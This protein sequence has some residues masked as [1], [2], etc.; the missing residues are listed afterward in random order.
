[1]ALWHD[2]ASAGLPKL[3]L[4]HGNGLNAL[5]QIGLMDAL[6]AQFDVYGVDFRGHGSTALPL[7]ATPEDPWG[8]YVDD[9]EALIERH[10]DG[11]VRYAGHSLSGVTGIRLALRR[12]DLFAHL[13]PIDPAILP[14]IKARL[15]PL[16]RKLG[17]T[18][19]VNPL[20][21]G[22]LV[23]R[24]TW[25]DRAAAVAYFTGRK[26]FATWPEA[27]VAGY[28]DGGLRAQDGGPTLTLT[29]GREWEARTFKFVPT[30][31]EHRLRDLRIPTTLIRAERGSIFPKKLRLS[32]TTDLQILP[33]T[34]F[35]H[36]ERP[37]AT[38]AIICK[39]MG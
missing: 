39:A 37:E 29:C 9:L 22:T 24:N 3:L 14:S 31:I 28:I 7:P 36:L 10:F 18:S 25:P 2:P 27:A 32:R 21:R 23:R 33:G 17:L 26:A 4:G 13:A 15:Y 8:W 30:E 20:Y 6:R 11:H 34:H 38:A 12:P 5:C 19:R 16:V 1:M 35:T